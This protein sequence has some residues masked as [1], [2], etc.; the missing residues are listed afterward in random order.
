MKIIEF[1]INGDFDLRQTLEC[2][3]CFRWE[4]IAKSEYMVFASDNVCSAKWTG[5]K[6]ILTSYFGS[7]EFWKNYFD[8]DKNYGELKEELI[9]VNPELEEAISYG[10]GIRILN[11]DFFEVLISFIIS[12]N[13]NIPRIKKCIESL[14]NRYGERMGEIKGRTIYAF[15]KAKV[16]SEADPKEIGELKLGYR[17]EYIVEAAKKFIDEGVPEGNNF[18]KYERL[19]SYKGIGPKVANCISLFGF[20]NLKAFPIDTWVR[21][22]MIDM[23]GFD[24]KDVKGMQKFADEN[25]GD[26]GG[27]AQ[28]YLFYFYRDKKIK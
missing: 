13:N 9:G 7:E 26:F 28:Q 4:E 8:L 3:Q 21:K 2:G 25:F 6:L 1:A 23:Y 5:E 11:Q 24:E 19:L 10:G 17:A 20:R 12:Q 27:L 16:L 22:I 15:P 18:E 14:S